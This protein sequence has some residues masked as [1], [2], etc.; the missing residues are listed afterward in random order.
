M[1][2]SP[3]TDPA[4]GVLQDPV[5][6]DQQTLELPGSAAEDGGPPVRIDPAMVDPD[7]A[8]A[9]RPREQASGQSPPES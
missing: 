2:D 1:P 5:A 9:M 8:Q 4:T 6:A 7:T 3:D